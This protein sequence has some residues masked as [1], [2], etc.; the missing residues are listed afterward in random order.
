MYL[1]ISQGPRD[2][3]AH[4]MTAVGEPVG[5][6]L[7]QMPTWYLSVINSLTG[8]TMA[9]KTVTGSNTTVNISSYLPGLYI[10]RAVYN[11][12]IYTAK[13]IK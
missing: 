13:F 9:S 1:C 7:I 3:F 4:L 5:G 11:G 8:A 12:S 2:T 10:V 6:G